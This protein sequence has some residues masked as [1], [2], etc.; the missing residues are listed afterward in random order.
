[1][2]W[3]SSLPSYGLHTSHCN[4]SGRISDSL[5]VDHK[6]ISHKLGIISTG[7]I[8]TF[9]DKL[10]RSDLP[11]NFY[12]LNSY[13]KHTVR[14]KCYHKYKNVFM[15]SMLFFS[16]NKQQNKM[17]TNFNKYPKYWISRNIRPV[18]AV[19]FNAETG[20]GMT[21]LTVA[22]RDYFVKTLKRRIKELEREQDI[23]YPSVTL[24][25]LISILCI[26]A[27]CFCRRGHHQDYTLFSMY[28]QLIFSVYCM[29]IHDDGLCGRNILYRVFHDFR[30]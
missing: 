13:P 26:Y 20:K 6:K 23:L 24:Y 25:L 10:L 17:S 7:G 4:A 29:V 21:M 14:L 12:S 19:L 11:T 27:T 28:Y 8:Y 16:H 30:T 2:C 1:M 22:F 9:C 5:S 15:Q 3:K 18:W